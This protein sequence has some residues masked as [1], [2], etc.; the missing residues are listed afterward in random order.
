MSQFVTVCLVILI[1]SL[2][3]VVS[4]HAYIGPQIVGFH[5]QAIEV[6]GIKSNATYNLITHPTLQVNAEFKYIKGAACPTRTQSGRSLAYQRCLKTPGNYVATIS[7]QQWFGDNLLS[8][9]VESGSVD[10]GF[11]NVVL[12]QKRLTVGESKFLK[13]HDGSYV[14][15]HYQ[16]SHYVTVITPLFA[17]D[18]DNNDNFISHRIA[19]RENLNSL[20][21]HGLI[22]QT[23]KNGT[24]GSPIS[25]IEG[26][27]HDYET[28]DESI[29][30]SDTKFNLFKH[31]P[32]SF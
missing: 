32:N 7:I 24:N 18:F 6:V 12:N 3:Q 16:Q 20:K 10:E 27:L 17:Y 15:F 29:Y 11:I 30:S 9:F 28:K 25:S 31:R 1:A 23:W 5:G 19:P 2:N 26:S 21:T 8:F 22:G 13:L 14:S 4:E